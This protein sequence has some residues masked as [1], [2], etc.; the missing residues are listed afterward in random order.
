MIPG[1]YTMTVYKGEL[2]AYT[3][4]VTVNANATTTVNTRTINNDPS[5]ASAICRIG[6]WDGT[7]RKLLNG[8]TISVRHPSDSRNPSWGPVTYAV[9]SATNKFPA[10]AIG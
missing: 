5:A 6:N 9:G 2:A 8:Q 1:T 7:P 4:N 3:E 10:W